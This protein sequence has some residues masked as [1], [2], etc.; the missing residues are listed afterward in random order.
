MGINMSTTIT[1]PSRYIQGKGEIYNIPQRVKGYGKSF[2]LLI[3]SFI[4]DHYGDK[5][6]D[7]FVQ[8][9]LSMRFITFNGECTDKEINRLE[10]EAAGS[11]AIIGLGGGKTL[12]TVKA[13]AY[14]LHIPVII[15]PTIASSD[16][17]CSALSAV[18]FEDGTFDKYLFFPVNPNC[19]IVDTQVVADAPVRLLVAGMGDSLATYFEARATLK[20]NSTTMAGGLS[21][22]AAQNMAKLC[23]ETL[24]EDGFKAKIAVSNHTVTKS[25]E[26]IIETNTYLSGIGFESGGLAAAHAIH[27]GL[28]AIEGTHSFYHGE[29]VAFGTIVQLAL[30]NAYLDELHEVA[31]FCIS[32]GLPITF[33]DLGIKDVTIQQLTQAAELACDP[34]DTMGN[35]PFDISVD[36]V[37]T[38]FYTANM[39]GE[40]LKAKLNAD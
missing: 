7:S 17:P 27:N 3:D 2:T 4:L 28:T 25:V 18:Y 36:D 19:V 38:A 15:F 24:L 9:D 32:V 5:I 12:D 1:A 35:M 39:V 37:V 6:R 8:H 33:A 22:L 14:S 16:A 10:K 26:N 21:T 20:S 30:E 40:K 34:N 29:K 31:T 13:A 23:Y 11:D